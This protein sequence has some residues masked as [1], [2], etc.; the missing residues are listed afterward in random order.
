MRPQA[1]RRPLTTCP[2]KMPAFQRLGRIPERRDRFGGIE[3][4]SIVAV[5]A[6]EVLTPQLQP[7]VSSEL[8]GAVSK[9]SRIMG[10]ATVALVVDHGS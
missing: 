3:Q 8:S 4:A 7:Q 1:P 9:A 10:F 5:R 6:A 2:I